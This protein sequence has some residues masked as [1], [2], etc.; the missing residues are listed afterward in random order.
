MKILIIG[1]DGRMTYLADTLVTMGNDVK[2]YA[3]PPSESE[4]PVCEDLDAHLPTVDTVILPL[5]VSRDGIFINT[6]YSNEKIELSRIFSRL[7]QKKTILAGKVSPAIKNQA[8]QFSLRV[9]DYYEHESF[10]DENAYITAEGALYIAME[11]LVLAVR[12]SHHL[13]I[14]SGR[15]AKH[16]FL[17]LRGM[18]ARVTI[19]C[20]NIHDILWA[21]ALRADVVDLAGESEALEGAFATCDVIYNTVPERVIPHSCYSCAKKSALYIELVGDE[22]LAEDAKKSGCKCICAPALPIRY[23]PESASRLLAYAVCDVI[24]KRVMTK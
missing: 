4:L 6:P 24:G 21:S 7:G 1:G 23:A 22:K 14:G 9:F 18:G 3:T 19:V 17:L 20:R 16:L 8:N 2:I 15:I 13:I 10:T 12:D 5:P 11:N